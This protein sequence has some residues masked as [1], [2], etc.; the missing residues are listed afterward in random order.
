MS[1]RDFVEAV[2]ASVVAY[3]VCQWLDSLL[4]GVVSP[5]GEHAP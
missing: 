2:I 1:V 5:R 3:Y 4:R